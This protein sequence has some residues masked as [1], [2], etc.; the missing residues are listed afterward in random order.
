M[1]EYLSVLR[2][3]LLNPQSFQSDF[4]RKNSATIAEAASRGHVSAVLNNKARDRWFV[5]SSGLALVD[6]AEPGIKSIVK[7]VI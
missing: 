1:N 4:S 3:V 7:E 6:D 5:T 2:H